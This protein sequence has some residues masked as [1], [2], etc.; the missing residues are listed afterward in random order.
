MPTNNIKDYRYREETF[1]MNFIKNMSK[2]KLHFNGVSL[3][4]PEVVEKI[5][6]DLF[7]NIQ[8][9]FDEFCMDVIEQVFIEKTKTL[10]DYGFKFSCWFGRIGNMAL[11]WDDDRHWADENG[12]EAAKALRLFVIE[13]YVALRSNDP[14]Y[15]MYATLRLYPEVLMNI[16]KLREVTR[17]IKDY[18]KELTGRDSVNNIM[19]ADKLN[20]PDAETVD[21][22]FI[23]KHVVKSFYDTPLMKPTPGNFMSSI[24]K[25]F[26][27]VDIHAKDRLEIQPKPMALSTEPKPIEKLHFEDDIDD[28]D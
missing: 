10:A 18:I 3:P 2:G 22:M 17:F 25:T 26:A 12:F 8:S 5:G 7:D 14:T 1:P 28:T 27:M 23:V 4:D 20:N 24:V 21:D 15:N 13:A 9:I 19:D 16:S 6:N 11:G